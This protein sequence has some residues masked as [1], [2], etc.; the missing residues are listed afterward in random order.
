[1]TPADIYPGDDYVDWVGIDGFNRET[2][3]IYSA[4]LCLSSWESF[5][6]ILAST[7]EALLQFTGKPMMIAETASSEEG[8][9]KSMW[10]TDALTIQFPLRF[11]NVR[12][13]A[14]F[15]AFD[16]RT[17]EAIFATTNGIS[18]YVLNWPIDTSSTALRAFVTAINESYQGT[19]E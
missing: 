13:L 6:L 11:P 3:V 2:S 7:Y 5:E 18:E 8:G 19:L 15:Y 12:A 9:S 1:M 14:W 10:I 16:Y 4:C 17:P